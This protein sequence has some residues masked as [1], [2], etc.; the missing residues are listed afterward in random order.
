LPSPLSW[1]F[2]PWQIP[3][4]LVKQPL[5]S[6]NVAQ[7][8]QPLLNALPGF[9]DLRLQN[10]PSQV[11]GWSHG[12]L[13]FKTYWAFPTDHASNVLRQIAPKAPSFLKNYLEEPPGNLVYIT[14]KSEINWRGIP[15]M[16]PRLKAVTDSGRDYLVVALLPPPSEVKPAPQELFA[17]LKDRNDLL[18]YGWEITQQRLWESR[19]LYMANDM[20][21]KR[22][23]PGTNDILLDWS[24]QAGPRLGNTATEVSMNSPTELKVVR[25]SHIGFTGF[26]V[27]T[28]VRWIDSPGFPLSY[29]PP[30]P[31]FHG[32]QDR[33]KQAK[34]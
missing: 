10:T 9:T 26:E 5:V 12:D 33:P 31:L 19:W 20:F 2:Q 8:I 29:E 21:K 25:K 17:Q 27:A 34:K 30:P 22:T 15:F 7:G 24:H 4:N 14:N 18:Y 28:L 1:K 11:C 32:K 3:T 23:M 6:F 13:L 16:D